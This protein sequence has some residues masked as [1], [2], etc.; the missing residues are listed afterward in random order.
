[1]SCFHLSRGAIGNKNGSWVLG[2]A[3]LVEEHRLFGAGSAK[4]F[5][6]GDLGRT[7][8]FPVVANGS[9]QLLSIVMSKLNLFTLHQD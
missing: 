4:G 5:C 1:M 2:L 8:D 9:Q 3:G 6:T 7:V